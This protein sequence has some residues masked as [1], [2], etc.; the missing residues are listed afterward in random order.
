MEKFEEFWAGIWEDNTQM[1]QRR[2]MNTVAKRIQ[3]KVTDVQDFTNTE[4]NL[5]ETIRKRKN[6]SVPGIDGMP[7][8]W[9]KKM[10]GAWSSLIQ[11]FKKWVDQP[12]EI[13]EWMT[14]GR[15]VLQPKSEDLSNE[16]NHSPITCLNTCYKIFTGMI[17]NY[18]KEHA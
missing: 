6:W 2:W 8:F 11:C 10:R 12:E 13:P 5:C 17:G 9:W 16:R 1:P 3:E 15:T 4:K 18:M 14:Q 7:N